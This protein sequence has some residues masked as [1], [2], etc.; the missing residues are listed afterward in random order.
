MHPTEIDYRFRLL[1]KLLPDAIGAV[2]SPIADD[3]PCVAIRFG[4]D[5]PCLRDFDCTASRFMREMLKSSL[6][7]LVCSSACR[8]ATTGT[9]QLCHKMKSGQK[10]AFYLQRCC[11]F[12]C[13][14]YRK[15]G[16]RGNP[17]AVR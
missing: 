13:Q 9:R 17:L 16:G 1:V 2:Q 6:S 12:Q 7:R 4:N 3:L 15:L 8:C 11:S 14:H 5:G 10:T